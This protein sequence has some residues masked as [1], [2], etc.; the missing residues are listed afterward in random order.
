MS[1]IAIREN[2]ILEKVSEF[3]VLKLKP[4]NKLHILVTLLSDANRN[5]AH[6]RTYLLRFQYI[7]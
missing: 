6:L 2:K 4:I 3:T 1:F 7:K 5:A